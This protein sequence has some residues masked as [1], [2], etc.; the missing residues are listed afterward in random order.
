[1][2]NSSFSQLDSDAARR[3]MDYYFNPAPEHSPAGEDMQLVVA[4][5]DLTAETAAAQAE[6]LLRCASSSAWEAAQRMRDKGQDQML[7]VMHLLNLG[8]AMLD[9]SQRLAAKREG[10]SGQE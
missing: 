9:H 7:M 1:M 3:A 6:W 2:S 10:E 4:R 5:H 8:R